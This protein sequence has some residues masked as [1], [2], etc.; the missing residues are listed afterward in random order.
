MAT[1]EN[2]HCKVTDCPR[3]KEG[4]NICE[5]DRNEETCSHAIYKN[6]NKEE[7]N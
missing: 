3:N 4:Q 1:K 6:K 7:E 5:I 2:N